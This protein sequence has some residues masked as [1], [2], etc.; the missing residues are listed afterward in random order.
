MAAEQADETEPASFYLAGAEGWGEREHREA[1]ARH[2][3]RKEREER[4]Y[5]TPDW[6]DEDQ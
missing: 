4:L 2:Q 1:K 6:F 5:P 3:K